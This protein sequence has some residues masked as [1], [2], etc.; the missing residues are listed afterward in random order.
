MSA[1]CPSPHYNGGGMWVAL[2]QIP[3][4]SPAGA[5][6]PDPPPLPLRCKHSTRCTHSEVPTGTLTQPLYPPPLC[7]SNTKVPKC[8]GNNAYRR[9]DMGAYL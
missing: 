8:D 9:S 2:S 1:Q 3:G 4:P 6:P 7:R 5:T